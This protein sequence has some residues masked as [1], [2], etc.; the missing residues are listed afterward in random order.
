MDTEWLQ[1]LLLALPAAFGLGW[2]ASRYDLRQWRKE[3]AQAASPLA[4]YKGLNLLLNEQHDEAVDAFI[5]AMQQDSG[6]T[7]LHFSLGELF[8]KRGETERAVRVHEHLLNRADLPQAQRERAQFALAQDHMKA[9]LFDRAERAYEALL[10]TSLDHPARLALLNLQERTRHWTAA[11]ALAQSL[12]GAGRGSFAQRQANHLCE[13]AMD[14]SDPLPG[15]EEART[16]APDAPRPLAMLIAHHAQQ[17]QW[18]T[19][20]DLCN[21]FC[22]QHPDHFKLLAKL[23]ADLALKGDDAVQTHWRERLTALH[24]HG[25]SLDWLEALAVLDP[26]GHLSRLKAHLVANPDLPAANALLQSGCLQASATPNE[27]DDAQTAALLARTLDQAC[28]PLKRY[29]CAACG[30]ESGR[31]FWQ[32]PGCHSWDSFP[33]TRVGE[34]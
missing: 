33:P 5:E 30:F 19:A 10:G 28:A 2:L 14:A 31:Y 15:L 22:T 4:L 24:A 9:G 6:T 13:L 29:R 11:R 32:C 8:R 20:L 25:P 21:T 27:P 23:T 3:Q 7:D 34:L 1:W 17:G 26:A 16:V 18:Q 12:D